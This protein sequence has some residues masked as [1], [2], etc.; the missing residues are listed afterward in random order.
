MGEP[1]QEGNIEKRLE[2]SKEVSLTN[3]GVISPPEKG[4]SK[5]K[6]LVS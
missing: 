2:G 6:G 5:S 4:S 1:Y 3:V